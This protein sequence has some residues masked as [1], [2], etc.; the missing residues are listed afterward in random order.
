LKGVGGE[1]KAKYVPRGK[2]KIISLGK[3]VSGRGANQKSIDGKNFKIIVIL[4]TRGPGPRGEGVNLC[5]DWFHKGG[6]LAV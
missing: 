3:K 5:V 4:C 2:R 6:I 1:G